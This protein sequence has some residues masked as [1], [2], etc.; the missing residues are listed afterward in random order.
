HTKKTTNHARVGLSR[1][2]VPARIDYFLSLVASPLSEKIVITKELV[3]SPYHCVPCR[4][5]G[6]AISSQPTLVFG[7][8]CY[9]RN[10]K[11]NDHETQGLSP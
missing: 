3:H 10:D 1:Y 9:A 7:L 5:N 8:L 11:K 4:I 2:L 6:A